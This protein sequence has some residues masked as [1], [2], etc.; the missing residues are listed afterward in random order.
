MYQEQLREKEQSI[1]ELQAGV[2]TIR[3]QLEQT[4]EQLGQAQDLIQ[5][6]HAH[7]SEVEAQLVEKTQAVVLL[8]EQRDL[9]QQKNGEEGVELQSRVAQLESKLLARDEAEKALQA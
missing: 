9:L 5:Q 4:S 7:K 2:Q 1:T 3:K 6:L 8:T